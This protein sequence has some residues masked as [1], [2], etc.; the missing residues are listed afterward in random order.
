MSNSILTQSG[1]RDLAYE[2]YNQID[3]NLNP[4]NFRIITKCLTASNF[5]N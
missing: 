3:Y 4:R 2:P 5:R 1:R